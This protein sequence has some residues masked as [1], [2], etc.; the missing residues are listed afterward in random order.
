MSSPL[1]ELFLFLFLSLTFLYSHFSSFRPRPSLTPFQSPLPPSFLRLHNSRRKHWP[2]GPRPRRCRCGCC[3]EP[4]QQRPIAIAVLPSKPSLSRQKQIFFSTH[5]HHILHFPLKKQTIHFRSKISCHSITSTTSRIT[6]ST[7][8]QAPH[9]CNIIQ[10]TSRIINTRIDPCL[11]KK[12]K[13]IRVISSCLID[14]LRCVN[15][16]IIV[17][18]YTSY[19]IYIYSW[20]ICEYNLKSFTCTP[21]FTHCIYQKH[22]TEFKAGK[23]R[24]Q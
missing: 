6:S 19:S 9:V 23:T 24:K 21:T 5:K 13:K 16:H 17:I 1:A 18:I 2:T 8:G 20:I 22:P 10:N 11:I 3:I 14:Y 4:S 7:S 15:F 12:K